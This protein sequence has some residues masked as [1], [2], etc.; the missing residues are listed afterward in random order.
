MAAV[1]TLDQILQS[2]SDV[3]FP[4]DL[5]ERRV[6]VDS[7]SVDGDTPLHVLV[8]RRDPEGVE[9]LLGAG[10]E[11]DA[12]GEMGETPLHVAIRQEHPRMAELLLKAGA[13]VEIRS[14]FGRTPLE[15]AASKGG[16]LAILLK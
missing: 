6:E 11:V 3:L 1:R 7:R 5:G 2:T 16:E 12:A 14:E 10:A 13:N 15:L 8:W 9:V 4:A